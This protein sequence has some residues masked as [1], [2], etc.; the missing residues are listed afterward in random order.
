MSVDAN[1]GNAQAGRLSLVLTWV[2]KLALAAAF[3]AAAYAKLTSRADMVEHFNL[4]GLGPNFIYV[5]G[6][7]ELASVVLLLVPPTA[8]L[9]A[10]GL[11]GISTGAFIAQIGPLHGDV[12]HVYVLGA[13][14]LL[15]AW[16][17]TPSY[18]R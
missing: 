12:I 5:T 14:A 11:V 13:L 9:G 17:T 10:L 1:M 16:V 7:I 4:L 18:L 2:L 3:G 8:F 6:G 15:A